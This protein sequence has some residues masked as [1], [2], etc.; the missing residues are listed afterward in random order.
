MTE[1]MN[2]IKDI[3]GY[4][5]ID[6]RGTPTIRVEIILSDGSKGW[7]DV[8]SGAST[9]EYEAVEIRD[10]LKEYRGK[11]V[12]K[13][14][15]TIENDIKNALIG[16]DITQ[17]REIDESLMK[18]DGTSNKSNIGANATLPV[19]IAVARAAARTLRKELYEILYRDKTQESFKGKRLDTF[20]LPVPLFNVI[21]GGR[22]ASHS[23]DF[24]EFMLV[25]SG[26]NSFSE[27]VR[28][29]VEIYMELKDLLEEKH[30]S[31]N[32][33][34]E[35]GFVPGIS[36]NT[37]V[38]DLLVLAIEKA[39]FKP[40]KDCFIAIDVAASELL[41]GS[42]YNLQNEKKTYTTEGFID[43]L[44]NLVNQYPIISIE[45]GL[46]END[47]DAWEELTKRIGSR[48]QLVGDDFLTTN[49]ERIKAAV[50]KNAGNAVLIKP[51]QIGTLTET[52][53]AVKFAKAS[54]YNV[55]L[56]H[57]S[58][59]TED[60]TISDLS[61]TWEATQIKA[62]APCRGERVA[63]YNRLLLI[64]KQM[65]GKVEYWGHSAYSNLLNH[66]GG[67]L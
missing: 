64:E 61:V 18:L 30:L 27:S 2:K 43:L 39:G 15:K 4:Q 22:H 59:D 47:F 8:P 34:D 31:T 62:G 50:K 5:I 55:I 26:A 37:K 66:T 20:M 38:L 44:E 10:E 3:K 58:G 35:G 23:T 29:G 13:L 33:G 7:G 63:K 16:F 36:S 57:R 48:V 12:L 42:V 25:P 65:E 24:Q 60:T 21:N 1:E 40:G 17:Q 11:G 28:W 6:S 45:D 41:N 46:A 56:S 9:G 32:V 52:F 67:M 19:S 49:T 51:N 53:E 54:G 14:V